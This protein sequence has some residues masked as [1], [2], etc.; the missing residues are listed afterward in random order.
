MGHYFLDIQYI[1]C[2]CKR[3]RFWIEVQN[4]EVKITDIFI[5]IKFE[6]GSESSWELIFKQKIIFWYLTPLTIFWGSDPEQEIFQGLYLD[7][8]FKSSE[9][10]RVRLENACLPCNHCSIG[11]GFLT[12]CWPI[13]IRVAPDTEMAGY[14]AAGYPAN[15]FSGYPISGWIV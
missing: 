3:S 10:L 12:K 13:V 15:L 6:F 5:L 4:D 8:H 1:L 11:H 7:P 9:I 14:P 2:F